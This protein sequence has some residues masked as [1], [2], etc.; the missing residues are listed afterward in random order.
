MGPD[1]DPLYLVVA[2]LALAGLVALG[3]T[4]PSGLFSGGRGRLPRQFAVK[5]I[6]SGDIPSGAQR[7]LEF[8][9]RKLAGL[10][11]E[12]ADLPVRVPSLQSFGYR[13][14]IVPFVHREESTFFF[15]G[16]E[17]QLWPNA[18][19]MLH[20]VTPLTGGQ[21]VE[22]TTLAALGSLTQPA[23]TVELRVV[24]DAET[25]EEIWSR[26]RLALSA[27]ERSRRA[28]ILP[29]QWRQ[30]AAATYEAWLQSGVRAQRLQLEAGGETYRVRGRPKSVV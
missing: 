23:E 4:R 17:Q 9:A 27:L 1:L 25:V 2:A 29:E 20:I 21:R 26:H 14:L 15:M 16:I 12:V 6:P 24:L 5:D 10:G 22:T 7:P 19:L 11:F 18:E 8:L 13:L 30:H 28:P 3:L